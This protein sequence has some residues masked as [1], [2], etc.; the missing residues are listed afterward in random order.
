MPDLHW[1]HSVHHD[2]SSCY[3]SAHEP[4]A[5]GSTVKL[6]V[7]TSL[8]APVESI[9][10]RTN[11][12]GEQH[13][14]P[15]QLIAKDAAACWWEGEIEIKMLKNNYR[16]LLLTREGHWWLTAAGM[17][18]YTPTD[19]S[20]FRLLARYQAPTWVHDTVFY[21]IFPDRF[22]DGDPSNNVR[23]GEYLCYGKPVV[24]RFWG[25]LPNQQ[26]GMGGIE[27]FG[28]DL[29]GIIQHLD[30]LQDLGINALY[31]TPI[32]TSPSNHKYDIIDYRHVD[33][34]FGGDE[35]LLTLRRALDE[36]GMRL[37]L[38]LVPN[39]CSSQHPWFLAALADATA[40][41]AEFFT[42]YRRPDDYETWH[43][44]HSLPKLNYQSAR[45]REEMYSGEDSVARH[46][47]KPPFRI[48]G[49]RVDVANM[50]ARQGE[51][52]LEHTVGRGLRRAIKSIAPHAY[53]IG[54]NF[55]DGSPQLQGDE[56]DAT[57]NYRGFSIPLQQWLVGYDASLAWRPGLQ[58]PDMLPTPALAEQWRAF[59]AAIPWQIATQQFNLLDSHDTRR[60]QTVVGGDE[61]LARIAVVL[62]FTF[63]GT[64]SVYYGDEIGMGGGTDPDSR[65]C[66]IW[67]ERAWNG[68]RR[69]F[70]QQLIHLRRS[71]PALRHGGLHGLYAA[72]ET[73]AFL[74]EAPK[75]RLLVVARRAADG[76][77]ALPV[78]HGGLPDGLVLQEIISGARAVVEQ[79]MLSLANMPAPGVQ[80]WQGDGWGL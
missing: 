39:H 31:L 6:R 52:Q 68:G 65:R 33:P 35:A 37:M 10:L 5:L 78:R 16:F 3:V 59:M 77:T 57:M 51:S 74:R 79:G 14:T 19:A 71:S 80:I 43:G 58:E 7:R 44:I 70:Y 53:L 38:D 23:D 15:L 67:D 60:I 18:R 20:D 72:G 21:Q 64:P 45:L 69:A 62:L 24:A 1:S 61:M 34:H 63:P 32:F 56:L 75:E 42:F 48:D 29:Q 12:D 55:F 73:I 4:I 36:R 50:L 30:Y 40:P 8:D 17:L 54:E 25:E 9:F 76:L 22:A 13:I 41:S 11:P 27:F 26:R 46:W 28:G 49:W 66:M 47:L 2:G